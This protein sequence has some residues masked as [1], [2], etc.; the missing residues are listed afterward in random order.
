MNSLPRCYELSLFQYN[1]EKTRSQR[2]TVDVKDAIHKRAKRNKSNLRQHRLKVDCAKELKALHTL[3]AIF[4]GYMV[5][6]HIKTDMDIVSSDDSDDDSDLEDWHDH[7]LALRAE[8]VRL[9]E[10]LEDARLTRAIAYKEL[11]ELRE[12]KKSVK[13]RINL[14]C[15][16]AKDIKDLCS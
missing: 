1:K 12:F 9:K 14:S 11:S 15:N 10:Q 4:T 3:Q 16:L 13:S 8:N 5:R 7:N 6:K 2:N